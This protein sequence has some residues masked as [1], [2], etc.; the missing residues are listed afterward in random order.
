MR[1]SGFVFLLPTNNQY[2]KKKKKKKSMCFL[3]F[4]GFRISGFYS[5][6]PHPAMAYQFSGSGSAYNDGSRKRAL[7]SDII[8]PSGYISVI[9]YKS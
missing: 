5:V 3:D 4:F 9:Y 1:I 7:D 6:R 8:T 2:K